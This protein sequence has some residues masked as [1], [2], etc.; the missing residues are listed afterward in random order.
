[1]RQYEGMS[2]IRKVVHNME[3]RKPIYNSP[4]FWIAIGLGAYALSKRAPNPKER[5]VELEI[6]GDALTEAEQLIENA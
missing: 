3:Q 2:K 5:S 1:M 4:V 6:S